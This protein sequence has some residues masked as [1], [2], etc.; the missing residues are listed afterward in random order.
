VSESRLVGVVPIALLPFE[1]DGRVDFDSLGRGLDFLVESGVSW[2]GF[3]FGSE[4]FRLTE[5]EVDEVFRFTNGHCKGK[6]S[7]IANVRAGSARAAVLRAQAAA[8]ARAVMMPLPQ[9][10][11]VPQGELVS[12]YR[13]VV[14]G[15]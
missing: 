13:A 2:V 1:Q 3:G 5:E 4:V 11:T 10:A 14:D 9:Y 6:L 12:L 8:G 15:S 7:I